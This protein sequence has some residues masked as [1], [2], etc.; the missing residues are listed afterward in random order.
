M[1]KTERRSTLQN[2][3]KVGLTAEKRKAGGVAAVDR[4]L[5]ILAVFDEHSPVMTLAEIASRTGLYKST[6]LRLLVSLERGGF[7]ERA[8]DGR[9]Q[10]GAEAWRV[11][12]LFTRDLTLGK[13]LL[14]IMKALSQETKESVAFY[15]PLPGAKPPMRM[16][17]LRVDAPRSVRHIFHVGSRLPIDKGAGGR[18]IRAFTDPSYPNDDAIRA[19]RADFSWG[20]L[21]PEVGSVSAPVMGPN[22]LLIGSLVLSTPCVR[23]DRS[24]LEAMKPVV[25]AAA[26]KATQNFKHLRNL[27]ELSISEQDEFAQHHLIP[28]AKGVGER[29]GLRNCNSRDA[30]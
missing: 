17:L 26:D 5:S 4:A 14:P 28:I 21:D 1:P 16:C 20:E 29:N 15:I 6:I 10:I 18:V 30:S 13:I 8:S 7:V 27:R 12:S 2:G 23:H 11:G 9:Y 22:G 24:W 25:I 19:Q 3:R